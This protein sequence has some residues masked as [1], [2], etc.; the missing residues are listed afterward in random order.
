[1]RVVEG[2]YFG[3]F[4]PQNKMPIEGEVWNGADAVPGAFDTS[5]LLDLS[6]PAQILSGAQLLM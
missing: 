3:A 6:P 1:M 2:F 5:V 4:A